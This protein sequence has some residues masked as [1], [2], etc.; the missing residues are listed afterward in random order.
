MSS[1]CSASM[2]TPCSA[3]QICQALPLAQQS[4]RRA[5]PALPPASSKVSIA[6]LCS[7]LSLGAHAM[8]RDA[9]IRR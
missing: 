5:L 8:V 1:P 4:D 2:T 7:S 6:A 9:N 3:A